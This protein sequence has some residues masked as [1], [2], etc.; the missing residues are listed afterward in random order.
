VAACTAACPRCHDFSPYG[1][2]AE[3][4]ACGDQTNSRTNIGSF[5]HLASDDLIEHISRVTF[6]GMSDDQMASTNYFKKFVYLWKIRDM[7]RRRVEVIDDNHYPITWKEA[8]FYHRLDKFDHLFH[9]FDFC[10][11]M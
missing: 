5:L 3:I 2:L 10:G 8:C 11:V 4:Q 6:G 9:Q 7:E 1:S